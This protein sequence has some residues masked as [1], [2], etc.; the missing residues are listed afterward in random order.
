MSGLERLMEAAKRGALDDVRAVIDGNS[1]LLNAKDDE[2]ATALHYAA[3]E[4]NR[5]V[6]EL[7]VERGADITAIDG[8]FG[9]TP[10]GWAIEYLRERGGYLGIELA[11]F[12]FAISKGQ[13][14]RPRAAYA[15]RTVARPGRTAARFLGYGGNREIAARIVDSGDLL[16]GNSAACVPPGFGRRA[17]ADRVSPPF[18]GHGATLGLNEQRRGSRLR[19]RGAARPAPCGRPAALIRA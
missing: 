15:P 18:A 9:A 16:W 4:G 12:A 1:D 8:K 7:L 6:V 13:R 3:F 5:P 14:E 11:D 2:G 19:V 17:A 10:A